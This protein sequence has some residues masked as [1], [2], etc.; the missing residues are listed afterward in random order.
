MAILP[1]SY[2]FDPG[3]PDRRYRLEADSALSL[4]FRHRQPSIERLPEWRS[5]LRGRWAPGLRLDRALSWSGELARAEPLLLEVAVEQPCPWWRKPRAVT[6]LAQDAES[7]RFALVD[8]EGAI[9]PDAL[10]R[11]SVLARP[12]GTP[13]PEL[14]LPEEPASDGDEW[15]PAVKLLHPR[16][17]WLVARL[18]SVFPGHAIRLAS[19]YRRDGHGTLHARGRALDLSFQGIENERLYAECKKL[20]D[21][22]CGFYPNHTFVHVDVRPYGTGRPSWVDV[23]NPGEP[24]QYVDEWF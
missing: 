7:D 8:C 18:A 14:P 9:A 6:I 1:T 13:R 11:L 12:P 4:L 23:S 5:Y 16:L 17:V 19:G 22:G 24:S 10:D 15:A 2:L 20:K 21:V 3:A